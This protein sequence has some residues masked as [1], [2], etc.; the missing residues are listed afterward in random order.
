VPD[1]S[2]KRWPRLRATPWR[3]GG[4]N[5]VGVGLEHE[6]P[7][8]SPSCTP[9]SLRRQLRRFGADVF[10]VVTVDDEFEGDEDEDRCRRDGDLTMRARLP[11]A[12]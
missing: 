6:A 3:L 1:L 9:A 11:P 12:W 2:V 7:A 5:G 10:L 8:S 4:G